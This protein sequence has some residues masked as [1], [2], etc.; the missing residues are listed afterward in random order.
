MLLTIQWYL[1]TATL[2]NWTHLKTAL[3]SSW[4]AG[5]SCALIDFA[6]DVS[7]GLNLAEISANSSV[8]LAASLV[9]SLKL[10]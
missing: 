2:F 9:Q 6:A 3:I 5:C 1:I 7:D 8:T 4:Q 10:C